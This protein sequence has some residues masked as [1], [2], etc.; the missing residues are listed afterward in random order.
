MKNGKAEP[1][2]LL[3]NG[4]TL[5]RSENRLDA[6]HERLYWV[7]VVILLALFADSIAGGPLSTGSVSWALRHM[8]PAR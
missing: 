3:A 8:E 7:A 6:Q 4:G 5:K 2:E 1:K